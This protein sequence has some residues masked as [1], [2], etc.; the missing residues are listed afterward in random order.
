VALGGEHYRFVNDL[1]RYFPFG[2]PSLRQC[3]SLVVEGEFEFGRGVVLRGDVVFRNEN[4][5]CRVVPDGLVVTNRVWPALLELEAIPGPD[6]MAA[7]IPPELATI[8]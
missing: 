1:D 3:D 4:G 8:E 7:T 6:G 2:A 5:K